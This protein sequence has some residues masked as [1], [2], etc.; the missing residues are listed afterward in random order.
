[1]VNKTI[2]LFHWFFN[3]FHNRF[4]G[5][6]FTQTLKKIFSWD[7]KKIFC[8]S[9]DWIFNGSLVNFIFNPFKANGLSKPYQM[10]KSIKFSNFGDVGWYF[11]FK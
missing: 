2:A 8:C 10:D 7:L 9:E 4:D 11:Y 3:N 5:R 1:M 6:Q